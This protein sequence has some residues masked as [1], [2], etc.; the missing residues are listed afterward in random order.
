[1][2]EHRSRRRVYVF[3]RVTASSR[4]GVLFRLLSIGFP[5]FCVA[6]ELT[7]HSAG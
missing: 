7:Y 5:Q 1:M 4:S 3:H 6:G 2:N